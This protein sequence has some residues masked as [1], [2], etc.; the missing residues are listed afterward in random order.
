VSKTPT[1]AEE[2]ATS[3]L[4]GRIRVISRVITSIY[5]HELRSV[6]LRTSQL[7]V[8]GMVAA[9]GPCSPAAIGK[10]LF[11]ERSTVSRNL[12]P[13]L[14]R[15]LLTAERG[16]DNRFRS[17]K[18]T[19]LGEQLLRRILPGWRRA[20]KAAAA[21]LGTD[22]TAAILHLAEA[23]PPPKPTRASRIEARR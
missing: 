14:T 22:G 3:C 1:P 17:V 7:N 18:V 8:L 20:Q 2:I 16:A 21:A 23:G 19:A 13:L 4:A 6:R 9:I 12:R 5:D 15:R 11:L 10:A